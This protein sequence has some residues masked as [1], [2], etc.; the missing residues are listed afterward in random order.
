MY[1]LRL[2]CVNPAAL[3]PVAFVARETI[4]TFVM[5]RV[6][7]RHWDGPA[8][9]S[10]PET[11]NGGVSKNRYSTPKRM[12]KIME[13]PIRMDDLGGKPTI[14]GNIQMNPT[15][16]AYWKTLKESWQGRLGWINQALERW[17]FQNLHKKGIMGGSSLAH[18]RATFDT[19]WK[20][21][22][23]LENWWLEDDFSFW[24]GHFFRGYDMIC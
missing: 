11:G 17:V 15:K 5:L 8:R 1:L 3:L 13:N 2:G 6:T 10:G 20:L 14:F 4:A 9:R 23:P 24:N 19:S 21:T 7:V 12:V 18:Q 16:T 22:Y